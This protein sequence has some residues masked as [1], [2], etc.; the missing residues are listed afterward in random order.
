M[1][2]QQSN[3]YTSQLVK[4]AAP[5]KF[6]SENKRKKVGNH[7]KY[8]LCALESLLDHSSPLPVILRLIR[9]DN[10][11]PL[12]Q[13]QFNRLHSNVNLTRSL[14]ILNPPEDKWIIKVLIQNNFYIPSFLE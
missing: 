5:A 2:E 13:G 14:V 7:Q 11:R 6:E 9:I 8:F 1:S 12:A 4:M 10:G 3:H